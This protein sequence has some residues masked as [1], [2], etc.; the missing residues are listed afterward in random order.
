VDARRQIA[1]KRRQKKKKKKM[2]R[3][4]KNTWF[5]SPDLDPNW[6][7]SRLV[8]LQNSATSFSLVA[9]FPPCLCVLVS[10]SPLHRGWS[11]LSSLVLSLSL[12]RSLARLRNTNICE[13]RELGVITNHTLGNQYPL[14]F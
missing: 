9:C 7:K 6:R 5:L 3:E 10:L 14:T 1:K 13:R 11:L 4:R 2:L 12:A 8:L